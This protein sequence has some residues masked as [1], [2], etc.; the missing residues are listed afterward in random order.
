[1]NFTSVLILNPYDVGAVLFLYMASRGFTFDK[2]FMETVS[3]SLFS[4][5]PFMENGRNK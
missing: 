2:T 5:D 1:M 4:P 3:T